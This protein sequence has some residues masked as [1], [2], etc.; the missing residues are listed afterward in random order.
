MRNLLILLVALTV[1]VSCAK[2]P[3]IDLPA[4]VSQQMGE[5]LFERKKYKDSVQYF[6]AAIRNAGDPSLAGRAQLMLAEA[7]FQL[8]DYNLAIPS[9]ETF[10]RI[11]PLSQFAPE[12]KLKLALCYYNQVG[13]P[14]R[15]IKNAEEALRIFNEIAKEN[16]AY[17]RE[18]NISEK[19]VEMRSIIS[20]RE[21]LIAKFYFRTD[22]ERPAVNRLQYIVDIFKDTKEYPEAL[23]LL[24]DY[25]AEK[26]GYES[27]AIKYY[28]VLL[29][30]F[31]NSEYSRS[32]KGKLSKLQDQLAKED[33]KKR[34]NK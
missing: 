29:S 5:E 10:L 34:N 1:A 2:K 27:E 25:Y 9:Y 33:K 28:N 4:D 26:D 31:P 17:D 30:E 11:Y 20:Q 22:K 8:K 19:I 21:M 6:E 23:M 12:A 18:H 13:S 32:V 7:H 15:D 3:A 14:E 24:G 16:P